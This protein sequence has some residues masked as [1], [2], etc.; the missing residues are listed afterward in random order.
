MTYSTCGISLSHHTTA[1]T[2]TRD[3]GFLTLSPADCLQTKE[4]LQL[5]KEFLNCRQTQNLN[6]HERFPIYL[7]LGWGS[8]STNIDRGRGCIASSSKSLLIGLK[9]SG[10]GWHNTAHHVS[11]WHAARGGGVAWWH[12]AAWPGDHPLRGDTLAVPGTCLLI[13]GWYSSPA[14]QRSTAG[15][16]VNWIQ[17]IFNITWERWA[18]AGYLGHG[19]DVGGDWCECPC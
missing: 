10:N 12:V 8:I 1:P 14:H 15:P 13:P 3:T 5:H 11:P 2:N 16:G 18:D 4:T 7:C 9:C 6:L 17:H 19:P